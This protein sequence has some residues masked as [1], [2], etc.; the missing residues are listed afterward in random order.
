M[1]SKVAMANIDA[2]ESAGAASAT[3][4]RP[5]DTTSPAVGA[6]TAGAGGD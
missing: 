1:P 6:N 3:L 2:D 4:A 5:G